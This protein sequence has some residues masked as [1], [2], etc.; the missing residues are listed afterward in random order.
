MSS[1]GTWQTIAPNSSGR[2]VSIT[3]ISRPPLEP[4]DDAEVRR[5]GDLARDQVLGDRAKSS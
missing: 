5:R 3:P 2:W 4:P 1:S